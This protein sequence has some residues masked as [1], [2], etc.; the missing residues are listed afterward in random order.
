VRQIIADDGQ[1]YPR[2]LKSIGD[3][4]P[5]YVDYEETEDVA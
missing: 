1:P 5:Q 3:A 2:L 4:P